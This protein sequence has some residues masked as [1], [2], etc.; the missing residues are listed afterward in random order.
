MQVTYRHNQPISRITLLDENLFQYKTVR[1]T[2][3]WE[4]MR[5]R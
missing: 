1:H 4:S 5:R 2:I 3:V